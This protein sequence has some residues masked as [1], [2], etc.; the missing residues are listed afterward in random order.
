MVFTVGLYAFYV[1]ILLYCN[2]NVITS[3]WI[4][5]LLFGHINNF[6][7]TWHMFAQFWPLNKSEVVLLGSKHYILTLL[8]YMYHKS[9]I[10]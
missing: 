5:I 6:C 7:T 10:Y 9:L 4:F 3:Y 1:N 2:T 8:Y